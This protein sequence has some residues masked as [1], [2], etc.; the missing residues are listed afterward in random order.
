[1]MHGVY[2]KV[3]TVM[4]YHVKGQLNIMSLIRAAETS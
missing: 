1:M 3:M 2:G 4:R